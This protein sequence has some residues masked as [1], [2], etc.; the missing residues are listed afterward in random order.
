MGFKQPDRYEHRRS[1]IEVLEEAAQQNRAP[2]IPELR[3][4]EVQ[5]PA[6]DDKALE[7]ANR[8]RKG[9][10]VQSSELRPY[11]SHPE[12]QK[13]LKEMDDRVEGE[14]LRS[15]PT[16][17]GR[18]NSAQ[19][20]AITSHLH[21]YEKG[22]KKALPLRALRDTDGQHWLELRSPTGNVGAV[23]LSLSGVPDHLR[24]V[25]GEQWQQK[26]V[27]MR[28]VSEIHSG[29]TGHT[30]SA[31][32]ALEAEIERNPK[33]KKVVETSL[34][35]MSDVAVRAE[36]GAS[37]DEI[38]RMKQRLH[39]ILG[40]SPIEGRDG[41]KRRLAE[42]YGGEPMPQA[43]PQSNTDRFKQIQNAPL[44]GRARAATVRGVSIE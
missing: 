12:V 25:S 31:K 3:T 18:L 43:K 36:V 24:A 34:K 15:K 41:I 1:A 10:D 22:E 30:D 8:L 16:K 7:L 9:R 27:G 33:F 28:V 38:H 44:A 37:Q 4:T 26:Q 5:P 17:D 19:T 29:G 42:I 14:R 11:R 13:A 32:R 20:R 2:A 23:P 35:K 39:K 6:S 21:A 40:T